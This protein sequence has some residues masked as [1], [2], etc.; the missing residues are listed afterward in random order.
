METRN[1]KDM[2]FVP[3]LS[4]LI[5]RPT[6][7][8]SLDNQVV[9]VALILSDTIVQAHTCGHTQCVHLRSCI[10]SGEV[11]GSSI[12][13]KHARARA[14]QKLSGRPEDNPRDRRSRRCV[15]F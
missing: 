12:L 6:A 14:G 13:M 7:T 8:E 1:S 15:T 2:F 5:S 10:S 3:S 4:I 9:E 11:A